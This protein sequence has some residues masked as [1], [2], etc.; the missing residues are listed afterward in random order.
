M[1]NNS[2]RILSVTVKRMFDES[3]DTSFLGE[4]SNSPKTEYAIDRAHSEDCPFVDRERKDYAYQHELDE[5]GNICTLCGL[6]AKET[7][8]Q[9]CS[10][11]VWEDDCNCRQA[12]RWSG[13][14]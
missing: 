1:R 6:E 7:L 10:E 4:Y 12:G 14:E 13:R 5:D 2:K 3:P 8:S 11:Y 9:P